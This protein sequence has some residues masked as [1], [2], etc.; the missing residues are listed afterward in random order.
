MKKETFER[1]VQ[2]RAELSEK[3]EKLRSFVESDDIR[4]I[5]PLNRDLLLTQANVMQS[6]LGVLSI[7]IGLNSSKVEEEKTETV[8]DSKEDEQQQQ[9][10]EEVPS[11]E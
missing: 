8:N 6:Y 10:P 3:F 5:D 11:Q 1:L 2:E 4:G 7:R 9:V